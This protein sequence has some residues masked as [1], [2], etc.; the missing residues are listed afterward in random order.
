MTCDCNKSDAEDMAEA[1]AIWG[2]LKPE[3]TFRFVSKK[4]SPIGVSINLPHR[5]PNAWFRFWQKV[6]FGF[7][8][9]DYKEMK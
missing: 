6:F 3:C 7:E 9:E 2:E 1:V 5:K 8:W 4:I